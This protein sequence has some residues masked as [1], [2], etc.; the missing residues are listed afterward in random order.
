MRIQWNRRRVV[1]TVLLSVATAS[2]AATAVAGDKAEG[3]DALMAAYHSLKRFNGSLLVAEHGEVIFKKGYG[4]AD[5]EW[6]VPNAPDTKFR[7]GSI[8]KQFTSMLVM[9][10]VAEGR[11]SLDTTLAEALPGY[12]QDTGG[13]VTIRELLNHTSGV[14]SYT[15]DSEFRD[16]VSRNPFT[17]EDFVK[18]Y[19]SGDLQFEPG[20]TFHYSNSG[21][22]LLGAVIEKVTGKPYEEVLKER[23]LDPVGM[24]DTGYDHSATVLAKRASGYERTLGGYVNAA[25]LDMSIPYA[26]GSLYSTV[27]DLYLWDR[28]LVTTKLLD[29]KD[30]Q[31]MFT[32]GLS[33]Y[34]FGWGVRNLPIGPDKGERTVI[35]HAGGINGF[36]TIIRRVP[37]DGT[38]VVLLNNTGEAPLQAV[39]DG[40]LDILYGRRP[41]QPRPSL[42]EDLAQT[43]SRSGSEA[44]VARFRDLRAKH[45]DEYEVS[46][47]ELNQLG[48][49]FLAT[50]KTDAAIAV[51]EINVEAFPKSGNVYDSLA[52][53]QAAAG[54]KEDAIKNYARSL[55]L[56][57]GNRNAV[58]RLAKLVH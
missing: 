45:A 16:K 15:E 26:A 56:D 2:W 50:G 31:M 3:I 20:T 44:A 28:A 39:S 57:P 43:I 4:F 30:K 29:A 47:A 11:L 51:F 25:Y 33:N 13:K 42:A 38:L 58:D 18:T 32:P 37:A 21:Y 46:E 36:S 12:R 9:Q 7:L 17:V 6:G 48:Y 49:Q 35:S 40:I 54:K 10:L 27:E 1:A 53:A 8:T 14:P 5:M 22:F 52:E 23:I 55:Q 41:P 19:C 24:H 34:A